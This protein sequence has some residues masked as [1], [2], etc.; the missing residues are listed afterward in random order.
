MTDRIWT[1]CAAQSRH[2]FGEV[3]CRYSTA[4][5]ESEDSSAEWWVVARV[6]ITVGTEGIKSKSLASNE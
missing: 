1:G 3:Y 6:R 5:R 4:E 2:G